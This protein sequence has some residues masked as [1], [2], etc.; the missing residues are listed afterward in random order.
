MRLRHDL[1]LPRPETFYTK[2]LS[3]EVKVDGSICR[4][5][6]RKDGSKFSLQGRPSWLVRCQVSPELFIKLVWKTSLRLRCGFTDLALCD[7]FRLPNTSMFCFGPG[8]N[9]GWHLRKIR[10]HPS[11]TQL[12]EHF[13]Q[14]R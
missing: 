12:R 11:N 4:S 5:F 1:E 9:G 7:C 2:R 3:F 8:I 6:T 10:G 14:R 13:T